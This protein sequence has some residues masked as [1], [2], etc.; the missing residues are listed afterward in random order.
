MSPVNAATLLNCV[1]G[2][3][4]V[5]LRRF[6]PSVTNLWRKA[7]PKPKKTVAPLA[8]PFSPE[9]STWA[10]AVPSGYSSLPSSPGLPC[11]LTMKARRSGII[12]RMPSRPPRI[13]T[14]MMRVRSISKPMS[15]RAGMVTPTPK[16]IDSPAEPAVCMMLFSRMLGARTPKTRDRPRNSVIASTATGI[17]ADTVMPTFSTR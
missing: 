2:S 10:Q 17:D 11:S 9:I 4:T 6:I 14:T 3:D 13:D 12:I 7:I 1:S 16:A 8:P 5:V 15:I